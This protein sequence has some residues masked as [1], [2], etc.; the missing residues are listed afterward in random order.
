MIIGLRQKFNISFQSC[1][2][3]V[4]RYGGAWKKCVIT[5][6]EFAAVV[7]IIFINALVEF[8]NHVRLDQG[9]GTCDV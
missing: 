8:C 7:T 1:L 4:Y 9:I 5:I 6:F 2:W 3:K